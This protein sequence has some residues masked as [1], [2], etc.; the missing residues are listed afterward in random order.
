MNASDTNK[1]YLGSRL[2]YSLTTW[3]P[4][5]AL[6]PDD[7]CLYLVQKV[8]EDEDIS[9]TTSVSDWLNPTDASLAEI[10]VATDHLSCVVFDESFYDVNLTRDASNVTS[11]VL[12]TS[13]TPPFSKDVFFVVLTLPESS[14][15]KVTVKPRTGEIS[16]KPQMDIGL[17]I[18]LVGACNMACYPSFTLLSIL[19]NPVEHEDNTIRLVF[20]EYLVSLTENLPIG[21]YVTTIKAFL[22]QSRGTPPPSL[23][24]H[25]INAEMPSR[26]FKV[27]E[28]S[29]QVTTNL[30]LTNVGTELTFRVK[31]DAEIQT[32]LKNEPAF[33]PVTALVKVKLDP[34]PKQPVF[35]ANGF[36]FEVGLESSVDDVIGS[37]NSR[38][39][40]GRAIPGVTYYWKE[41]S[42]YFSINKTSGDVKLI[43]LIIHSRRNKRSELEPNF[44]VEESSSLEPNSKAFPLYD[45]IHPELTGVDGTSFPHRRISRDTTDLNASDSIS[46]I[47]MI[48]IARSGFKE[49]K[50]AETTVSVK[51]NKTCTSNCSSVAPSDNKPG[52]SLSGTPLILLIVFLSV[53]IV[54]LAGFL[55][56][57]TWC[58]IKRKKSKNKSR[59]SSAPAI[60]IEPKR[61]TTFHN[62]SYTADLMGTD[63]SSRQHAVRSNLPSQTR[64]ESSGRG[65]VLER[66]ADEEIR[67]INAASGR[68]SSRC[69]SSGTR[70][71][72]SAEILPDSGIPDEDKEVEEE[73]TERGHIRHPLSQAKSVHASRV[74][75]ENGTT[76]RTSKSNQTGGKDPNSAMKSLPGTIDNQVMIP[77]SKRLTR[78]KLQLSEEALPTFSHGYQS[79]MCRLSVQS[80]KQ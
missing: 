57:L 30:L 78:S 39:E 54:L 45:S 12:K 26:F 34:E 4:L 51:I 71:K 69:S 9:L 24:F 72:Y 20:S 22:N 17:T 46:T 23:L 42:E 10:K 19:I 64:S 44:P 2:R 32:N 31:V 15:Q 75:V 52:S 38:D 76:S 68:I 21:S 53:G 28:N 59:K 66:D 11:F 29:G 60:T 48:A 70:Q 36:H 25:L 18:A 13:Q 77:P 35:P 37:V 7:G 27:D 14:N 1:G 58:L 62:Q 3:S 67:M 56:L 16:L 79:T 73:E 40:F 61:E 5:F 41:M 47:V 55:G 50:E 6:S 65:S 74:V 43:K 49:Q 33:Q 63:S 8:D 80:N